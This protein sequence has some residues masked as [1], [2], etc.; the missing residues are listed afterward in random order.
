VTA[1]AE[2]APVVLGSTTP[3]LWTPPLRELAPDTSYGFDVIDF[4][5]DVLRRPLDPWQEWLAIHGGELRRDGR[6]RFRKVLVLAARQN[7]K[8]ELPVILSLYWQFIVGVPLILGTSTKLDYAKESWVKAVD[9]AERSRD[10]DELRGSG[11]WTRDTNGEQESWTTEKSRY[12]I[13]AA[14]RNAG[15]S[16]TIHRL[17]LDE[18]RQH[19]TYAA[20]D[21]AINA[22]NAVMDFQAWCLTNAG[23]DRSVVLNELRE[24]ALQDVEAGVPDS[25]LG[26]FEWSSEENADP[27][28]I[29]AL[30]QAN[31]NLGR[32]IDPAVLLAAARAAVR[33]GG[34]K[35]TGFKTECMCIRVCV[36]SPA[37][38]P[39]AWA[40]CL[41]VGT[42]AGARSRLACCLDVAPDGEHVTLVAAAMLA[43]DRVRVEAVGSWDSVE[44]ARTALPVLLAAVRPQVLGWLPGGPA[45]AMA[46]DLAERKGRTQWPPPGIT[47]AE[48][49]GEVA[50]VCMALAEQ[51]VAGKIAHSDDPLLNAQ[52]GGAERL[53]RGEGWVFSR[54]GDGHCDA[55]YAMAGAVHLARTLPKPVGRQRLVIA[56]G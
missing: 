12:K 11:R 48:I 23:D 55:A 54:K 19:D 49:R 7:G 37:I 21:A 8:T 32:R 30:A 52:I 31:P 40:R 3:R 56:T 28:D 29:H 39:G 36:L 51:V 26:I 17:V 42:L 4:A 46:A 27:E 34:D 18:I 10:L 53:K 16:L 35:L 41:D 22:G 1:L 5:R 20:W 44:A 13:A 25:D 45:A 15:R 9:L 2:A 24:E 6:P 33:R 47:V 14:N 43:D 50:A 38:D